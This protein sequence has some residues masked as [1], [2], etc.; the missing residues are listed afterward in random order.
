MGPV[1]VG[2]RAK[3]QVHQHADGPGLLGAAIFLAVSWG[4]AA[5]M[6]SPEQ[7]GGGRSPSF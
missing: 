7:G 5:Y 1:H 6:Q 4:P 3:A 2:V